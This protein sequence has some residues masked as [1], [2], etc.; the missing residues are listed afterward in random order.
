MVSLLDVFE[1][2]KNTSAIVIL[3]ERIKRNVNGLRAKKQPTAQKGRFFFTPMFF[4]VKMVKVK[5]GG[6]SFGRF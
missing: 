6:L 3:R 1:T 5:E 4:C 2:I